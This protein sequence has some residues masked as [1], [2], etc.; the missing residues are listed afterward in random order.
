[1]PPMPQ[2][3]PGSPKILPRARH[4]KVDQ[5]LVDMQRLLMEARSRTDDWHYPHVGDL[6]FAYFMVACHLKREEHI[7]LWHDTEG[8]LVG[9]AILGEDP[10]IDWQ[11][12]PDYEWSGIE[13]EAIAWA[14]D[15]LDQLRKQDVRQWSGGLMS[16]ARQDNGRR[17]VFLGKHGFRYSGEFAEVNML[18]P[19]D[20]PIPEPVLPPRCQVRAVADASDIP[21]RAAAHREVWQPW[22]DGNIT[23]EDYAAFMQLP[24]YNCD[25]DL[26]AVASEGVIAA[27]VNGWLDPV[28]RIGCFGQVGALPA[29]RRRGMTRAVLLEG[30]R[31][32]QARG[33]NR[34]CISTGVSNVPAIRL[35]ESVG[36]DIENQYLDYAKIT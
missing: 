26:V 21:K 9:Y 1:M 31:R 13:D 11:A 23:D 7:R 19:L 25:L 36:F 29:Y 12:L 4:F 34:V 2:E 15:R 27:T 5:D 24:G 22:T 30:L 33:M 10:S 16:G 6:S 3:L 20:K 35:Y 32:M 28:N 17:R 18:R 8:R 14:E